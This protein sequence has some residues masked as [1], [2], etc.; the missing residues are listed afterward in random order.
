MFVEVFICV[1]YQRNVRLAGVVLQ[2]SCLLSSSWSHFWR[3]FT[4]RI[5]VNLT[6]I[7]TVTNYLV[8]YIISQSVVY[9]ISFLTKAS[10]DRVLFHFP[11]LHTSLSSL[12]TR[13][14]W[15]LMDRARHSSELV[16]PALF[17]ISILFTNTLCKQRNW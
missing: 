15:T 13:M 10:R 17:C 6:L 4:Y 11:C 16:F 5:H 7:L 12:T 2:L 9:C 3:Y 14:I 8:K 1:W